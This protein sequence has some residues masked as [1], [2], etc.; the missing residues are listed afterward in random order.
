VDAEQGD[1]QAGPSEAASAVT[2]DVRDTGGAYPE[3]CSRVP[4]SAC[5][6]TLLVAA[7]PLLVGA[8]LR[9]ACASAPRTVASSFDGCRRAGRPSRATAVG[10]TTTAWAAPRRLCVPH[11]PARCTTWRSTE[12]KRQRCPLCCTTGRTRWSWCRCRCRCLCLS[13]LVPVLVSVLAQQWLSSGH[14]RL[15]YNRK[16]VSGTPIVGKTHSVRWFTVLCA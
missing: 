7:T 9:R 6:S 2:E 10:S 1:E 12:T 14:H 16:L 15:V 8:A 11:R 3:G 4:A 5:G 13:E